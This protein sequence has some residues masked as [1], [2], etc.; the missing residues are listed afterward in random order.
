MRHA[1]PEGKV[2]NYTGRFALYRKAGAR[3]IQTHKATRGEDPCIALKADD[4]LFRQ[5]ELW[6]RTEFGDVP[7]EFGQVKRGMLESATVPCR[8]PD[9]LVPVLNYVMGEERR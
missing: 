8:T 9:V 1:M 7:W 2:E 6:F 4:P 5:W 3:H